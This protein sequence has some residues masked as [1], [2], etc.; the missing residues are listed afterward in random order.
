[1]SV[2][3]LSAAVAAPYLLPRHRGQ[4]RLRPST[5]AGVD[6]RAGSRILNQMVYYDNNAFTVAVVALANT[7]RHR[8]S[9]GQRA[10]TPP[11]AERGTLGGFSSRRHQAFR[12]NG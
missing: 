7:P 3:L 11:Q 8:R 2:L 5:D 4:L 9:S 1:M 12:R 6:I 10:R